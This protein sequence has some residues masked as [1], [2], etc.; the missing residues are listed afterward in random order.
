MLDQGDKIIIEFPLDY[1]GIIPLLL[2]RPAAC[3]LLL[4][5]VLVDPTLLF[6]NKM[7]LLP[8][9]PLLDIPDQF[10][11]QQISSNSLQGP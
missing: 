2:L 9:D 3:F 6:M 11:Q 1:M 10:V 4:G 5:L 8:L 7:L